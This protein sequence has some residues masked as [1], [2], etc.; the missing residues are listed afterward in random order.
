MTPGPPHRSCS[1]DASKP[2]QTSNPTLLLPS[3]LLGEEGGD[4]GADGAEAGRPERVRVAADVEG[5]RQPAAEAQA[6]L[7]PSKPVHAHPSVPPP[8]LPPVTSIGVVLEAALGDAAIGVGGPV[9]LCHVRAQ[10]AP[11]HA[12]RVRLHHS[13]GPH[14]ALVGPSGKKGKGNGPGGGAGSGRGRCR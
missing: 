1:V 13:T 4:V 12:L 2:V 10:V 6:T 11:V 5:L 3:L 7:Q 8:S 9:V 14:C